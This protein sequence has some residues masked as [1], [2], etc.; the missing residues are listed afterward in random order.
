MPGPCEAACP[1][2]RPESGIVAAVMASRTRGVRRGG[3]KAAADP[4]ATRKRTLTAATFD[5]QVAARLQPFYGSVFLPTI[6][7]LVDA[8]LTYDQVKALI[9]IPPAVGAKITAKEFAERTADY[10]KVPQA[11]K[12][13]P[14]PNPERP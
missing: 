10:R 4:K 14:G 6:K 2:P 13:A 5:E 7:N 9:Q 8:R 12:P 1:S 3:P 11:A